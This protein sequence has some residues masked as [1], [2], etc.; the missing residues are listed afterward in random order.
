MVFVI[1]QHVW[2]ESYFLISGQRP[3]SSGSE[4]QSRS[5]HHHTPRQDD[6]Q[7]QGALHLQTAQPSVRQVLR[8]W[9]Y[10][11]HG[12]GSYS[13]S[14]FQFH[15]ISLCLIVLFLSI[16]SSDK[17]GV[18]LLCRFTTGIWLELMIW[19]ERRSLTLRTD[20]TADIEQPAASPRNMN[21][22]SRKMFVI[23]VAK[24]EIE[25]KNSWIRGRSEFCVF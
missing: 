2:V 9:S 5:V 22:E 20:T 15:L 8:G 18:Y 21:C 16:L 24:K 10:V 12:V 23:I 14:R 25:T 6:H 13:A 11:S 4:R 3:S 17:F 1:W 19:L 7:R